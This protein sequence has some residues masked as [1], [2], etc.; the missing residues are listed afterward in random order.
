M[1]DKKLSIFPIERRDKILKYIKLNKSVKI[2]ELAFDFKVSEATV[3]R[4]LE[5]LSLEG[6]VERT[7]GGAVI[8]P[9]STAFERLYSEK[10]CIFTEEKQRIGYKAASMVKDNETLIL[11]SGSTTYHVAKNL[12]DL[13]NLTIITNDLFIA[14]NIEF[15]PSTTLVVTGG[16]RRSG[17]NILMG[18]ITEELLSQLKVNKTFLAADAVDFVQGISNATLF[19]A[20]IKRLII[21]AAQEV[22]LVVDHSKFGKAALARVC[23]LEQLHLVITDS[24]VDNS[25]L[26]GF[27]RINIPIITI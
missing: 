4:D 6:L 1:K 16:V 17:F 8:P 26:Q 3:R 10:L 11:D 12:A 5:I 27:Q 21:K 23:S 7:Y 19:E 15:H 24:G 14:S 22:I 9:S 2:K 20:S 18:S 13:K 25:V